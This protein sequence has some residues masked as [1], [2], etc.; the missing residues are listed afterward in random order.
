MNK[1]KLKVSLMDVAKEAMVSVTTVSHV[2]NNIPYARINGD[3]RKRILEIIEKLGYQPNRIAKSL[4]TGKT[5]IIGLAILGFISP[6]FSTSFFSE[7]I[8]GVDNG[9]EKFNYNLLLFNPKRGDPDYLYKNTI[10]SGLIDGIILEGNFIDDEFILNLEKEKFP[11]VLIGRELIQK[12]IN[13][14]TSDYFGGSYCAVNH[15]IK[16]GHRIIGFI[17]GPRLRTMTN[18]IDRERGYIK[19][20]REKGITIVSDLVVNSDNISKNTGYELMKK[21]LNN[22]IRPTAIIAANDLL[23]IGA[24]EA[25]RQK[26]LKIP[27][28][29]AV[30][31]FDDLPEASIVKPKLTTVRFAMFDMGKN[32]AELLIK[33]IN[34]RETSITEK[35]LPTKLIIRESCGGKPTHENDYN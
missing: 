17:G 13:C 30:I 11:Y 31:G 2:V 8:N 3:T 27:S 15:L 7:L 32:A 25:I 24:M 34:K 33:L 22:S 21:L 6:F 28:D 5:N 26:G 23:A 4:V 10:E 12:K 1:P 29:V 9:L 18:I 20:L 35:I 16:L 19:A 14:V